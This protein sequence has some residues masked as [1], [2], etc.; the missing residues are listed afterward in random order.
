MLVSRSTRVLSVALVCVMLATS[1]VAC[2]ATAVPEATKETVAPTAVPTATVEEAPTAAPAAEEPLK[3]AIMTSGPISDMGWN[4]QLDQARI[5]IQK[6]FGDKVEV[7][8]AENIP[9]GEEV[10][11]TVEQLIADGADVIFDGVF[12]PDFVDP[13]ILK[14]PDVKF[15]VNASAET[16]PNVEV[17]WFNQGDYQYLLGMAAGLLTKTNELSYVTPWDN[18]AMRREIN[19]FH[20][21]A[22]SVNP[23]ATTHVVSLNSW[24]DPA[25]ARQAAEALID[26]GVDVIGGAMDDA[27]KIV[28]A[29]ERGVWAMGSYANAQKQFA[30]TVWVNTFIM[31]WGKMLTPIVGSIL[32]GTWEG[33]GK[34]IWYELGEGSDI[35]EW[36][37]KVPQDV[38]DKVSAVRDKIVSGEF[39]P[40]KGPITDKDGNLVLAEGETISPEEWMLGLEW[41][42][43][44]VEGT[45]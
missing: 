32:D 24:Y 44:G 28:V 20:M 19:G 29:E 21:G 5:A 13:M 1:L 3:V 17:V 34:L 38:V 7:V 6:A 23:D 10:S 30:P 37:E 31:D 14:H 12:A 25:G 4:Y 36:G 26:S 8:L 40:F 16:A 42:L 45:Q 35:G 2:G 9:Y 39:V 43:E 22:R 18:A 33:N 11:R 15:I 27:T 41:V